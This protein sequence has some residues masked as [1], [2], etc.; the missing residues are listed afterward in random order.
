MPYDPPMSEV[1]HVRRKKT[2]GKREADLKFVETQ[3]NVHSLSEEKL[4]ELFPG[5]YDK[6]PDEVY[7]DLEY[8]PAKFIKHEHHVEIYAGKHGEGIVRADR[9]E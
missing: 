4:S 1:V 7:Y 9:P 8:V 5:G 3:I 6:L 2:K